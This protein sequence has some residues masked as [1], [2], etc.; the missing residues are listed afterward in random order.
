MFDHHQKA[1]MFRL[2]E[3]CTKSRLVDARTSGWPSMMEG[4]FQQVFWGGSTPISTYRLLCI[5]NVD[6]N[7]CP[8]VLVIIKKGIVH[9]S[10]FVHNQ[11]RE[12]NGIHFPWI[13]HVVCLHGQLDRLQSMVVDQLDGIVEQVQLNA[14]LISQ[15]VCGMDSVIGQLWFWIYLDSTMLLPNG[16]LPTPAKGT[17]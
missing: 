16:N 12:E 14:C 6:L 15:N 3:F 13:V 17:R 10:R 8:L 7:G 2:L 11:S 1:S 9:E 5:T 4:K